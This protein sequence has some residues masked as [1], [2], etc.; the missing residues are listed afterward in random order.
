MF[1]FTLSVNRLHLSFVRLFS[2]S[3]AILVF[4][5]VLH[6]IRV[7]WYLYD[8]MHKMIQSH[9]FVHFVSGFSH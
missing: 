5:E 3:A 1:A 8:N 6:V 9:N 4:Q 2:S 7:S